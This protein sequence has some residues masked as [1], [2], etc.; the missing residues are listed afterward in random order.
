MTACATIHFEKRRYNRGFHIRTNSHFKDVRAEEQTA[1]RASKDQK[2]NNRILAPGNGFASQEIDPVEVA[3]ST[4]ERINTMMSTSPHTSDQLRP[5]KGMNKKKNARQIIPKSRVNQQSKVIEKH[6]QLARREGKTTGLWYFSIF[7]FLP[8]LYFAKSRLHSV[9]K[10]ASLNVRK[11]QFAIAGCY[12]IGALSSFL[13]GSLAQFEIL[14]WMV[15]SSFALFAFAALSVVRKSPKNRFIGKRIA[16]GTMNAA[17]FFATFALGSSSKVV[18][19]LE[20]DALKSEGM[21][22]VATILIS[23]LLV[24]LLCAA[25]MGILALA[26]SIW[27]NGSLL[28]AVAIIIVGCYIATSFTLWGILAVVKGKKRAAEIMRKVWFWP[29]IASAIFGGYVF[30]E[31]E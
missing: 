15:G 24:A 14:S 4:D 17:S 9:S 13:L 19:F 23:I 28:G 12:G 7:G 22:T 3:D 30:F 11:A 8:I 18:S 21:G 10:W 16:Y 6:A 1:T 2:R 5:I 31:L 26:C 20:M 29:L 27:C 25:I